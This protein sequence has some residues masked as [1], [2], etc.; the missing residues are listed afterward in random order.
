M[1]KEVSPGM[2]AGVIAV[3]VIIVG[4]VAWRIWRAPSATPVAEAAAA[5]AE[6]GSL[7]SPRAGG[8]GPTADDLRK[9]DEY[10]RQHPDAAGSR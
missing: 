3:V 2:V 10:N 4:F 8:S 9:R 1:K 7:A 6:G 5:A